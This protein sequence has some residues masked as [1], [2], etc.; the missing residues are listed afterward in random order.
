MNK[1]QE[2]SLTEWEEIIWVP[3]VRESWGLNNEAPEEFA[4]SVY[5]VKFNF[6]SGSPGYIG[7][8]Y[9]LQGDVLTGDAPL[10][11]GRYDGKLQPV[12]EG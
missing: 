1:P 7:D 12:Y 6:V 9:I 5:G 2:I 10:I 8:L 4:S 11:L 3:E